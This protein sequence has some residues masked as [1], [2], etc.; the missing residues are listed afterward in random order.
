MSMNFNGRI[1]ENKPKFVNEQGTSKLTY[2]FN[3]DSRLKRGHNFGIIYVTSNMNEENPEAP[4]TKKSMNAPNNRYYNQRLSYDKINLQKSKE[5]E[6]KDKKANDKEGEVGVCTEK[7]KTFIRNKPLTFE[8]KTQTDPLPPPSIPI[9]VWHGKT[10]IDEECQIEDEDLFNFDEEVKPLIHVLISK[11]LEDA[12][13]EVLEE[14]ELKEII[15]QQ[16]KYKNLFESNNKKARQMEEDEKNR[17][18]E[19]KNNHDINDISFKDFQNTQKIN[20][21]NIYQN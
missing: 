2:N 11:T 21:K 10:G 15:K 1:V 19:H 4:K 3:T 17:F 13:R 14:E 6:M 7:I 9:L 18:E 16:E 5:N 12:R 20:L 8:V